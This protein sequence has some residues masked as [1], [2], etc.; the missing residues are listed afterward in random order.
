MP[1]RITQCYLPPGRGDIPAFTPAEAGILEET[2]A[3]KYNGLP[4]R[5]AIIIITTELDLCK[6][7]AGDNGQHDLLALGRVRVLDVLEQPRLERAGRLPRRVLSPYI[8]T[9]HRTVT[10]HRHHHHHHHHHRRQGC[11]QGLNPVETGSPYV[12]FNANDRRSR[13]L[14]QKLVPEKLVTVS[15]TYMTCNLASIFFGTRFWYRIEHV[16]FGIRNW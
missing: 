5:E 12:P 9:R 11:N 6:G 3:A 13:N 1:Y 4:S 10:E 16:L 15:G 7:H 8:Q 14:Y 2:T